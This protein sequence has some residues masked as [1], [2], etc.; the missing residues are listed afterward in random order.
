[1]HI[2]NIAFAVEHQTLSCSAI[3]NLQSNI[4]QQS[5]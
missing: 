5:G 3:E 2:L 4:I 1:M